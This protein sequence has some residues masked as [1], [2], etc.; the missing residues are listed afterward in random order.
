MKVDVLGVKVDN[1]TMVEAV[2]GILSAA[3]GTL[4]FSVFTP[5]SEMIME[6]RKAPSFMSVLNSASLVVP[7][8]SGVILGARFMGKRIKEKVAGVELVQNILS[9]GMELSLFIYGGKPGVA[10]KAA[11]NIRSLYR[12]ITVCGTEHGYLDERDKNALPEKI[13]LS[14]PD[15][16]LVGLGV[17]AQEN[18]I[19]ENSGK[20]G[21]A[22]FIGCGGTID[23][24]SG[25]A[26]RAPS[27]FIRLHL[28]W[29]YRLLK[30]PSRIGR[31]MRIPVF[32]FLCLK[33][34]FSR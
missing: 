21:G 13:R 2:E 4:P 31:M 19:H 11:E 32:L 28:E 27:V 7:D 25:E 30:E 14:S 24:L 18:W 6:A 26:R 9:S 34:R 5:N 3:G 22:V 33:K 16:V 20:I 15:I 23:I 29:L 12:N 1:I 8:G 10:G 17:P